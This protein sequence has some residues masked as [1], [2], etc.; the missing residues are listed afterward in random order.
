M[1]AATTKNEYTARVVSRRFHW[2]FTLIPPARAHPAPDV[3]SAIIAHPAGDFH[4]IGVKF[5]YSDS[6]YHSSYLA[7]SPWE[8]SSM[9][10]AASVSFS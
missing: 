2:I 4:R 10:L 8:S 1:A 6:A 5:S 9:R 7:P 3:S